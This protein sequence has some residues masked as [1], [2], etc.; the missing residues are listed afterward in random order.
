MFEISSKF[1]FPKQ[2]IVSDDKQYPKYRS[3]LIE[4]CY[5]QL[6]KDREGQHYTNVGGWQSH[7]HNLL[8]D[9][10]F[11]IFKERLWENINECLNHQFMIQDNVYI[12]MP[13]LWIN[14]SGQNHYN[15]SHTHPMSHLTGVFYIKCL[16]NC[17][18][19]EFISSSNANDIQ[20][21]SYR[22]NKIKDDNLMYE[23]MS[24]SPVE[25]RLLLFPSSLIHLVCL[26]KSNSDRMSI[27]FDL[28][29]KSN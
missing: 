8:W 13:R 24:F 21:L 29:F 25:G 5:E 28:V 20:E 1:I 15:V 16:E 19:I 27:S 9:E 17:G 22:K 10:K 11:N 26:N 23:S 3:Q 4:F 18:N 12:D 7:P 14:I 6:S 2:V